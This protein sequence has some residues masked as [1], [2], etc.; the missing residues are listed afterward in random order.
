MLQGAI[1]TIL[2]DDTGMITD[3]FDMR[4]QGSLFG[5]DIEPGV[6]HG[7]FVLERD[8]VVF[9]TKNGPYAPA[10]DKDFAQWAPKENSSEAQQYLAQLKIRS[11]I[12]LENRK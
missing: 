5:V 12:F 1:R 4:A 9:E 7:F 8:S 2:F 11:D 10:S 6:W 3:V